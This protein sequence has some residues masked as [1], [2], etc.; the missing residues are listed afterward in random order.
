MAELMNHFAEITKNNGEQYHLVIRD[1]FR[2]IDESLNAVQ[3]LA[4]L[5]RE[6]LVNTRGEVVEAED[7]LFRLDRESVGYE[8]V[9][10]VEERAA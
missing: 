6:R 4:M 9:I 2:Q 7:I 1:G 3:L 5:K 8:I 10:G